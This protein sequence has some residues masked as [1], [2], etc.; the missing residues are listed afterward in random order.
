MISFLIWF[1]GAILV[2]ACASYYSTK[3][4][5][6]HSGVLGIIIVGFFTSLFWAYCSKVTNN[7]LR[8]SLIWD[9]AYVASFSLVLVY[10][11]CAAKYEVK[12][13]VGIGLLAASFGYWLVIDWIK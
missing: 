5:G 12:H 10:F 13:W 11:G 8:D 3:V 2:A 9:V 6:G 4:S 7:L 1:I